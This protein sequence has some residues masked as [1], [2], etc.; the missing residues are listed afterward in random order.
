VLPPETG[1]DDKSVKII[2]PEP[3]FKD[4]GGEVN[5]FTVTK[6]PEI[7][8]GSVDDGYMIVFELSKNS[9]SNVKS[10]E[11]QITIPV[12]LTARHPTNGKTSK[13]DDLI[14]VDISFTPGAS[15]GT[16]APTGRSPNTK[17]PATPPKP[18]AKK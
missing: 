7:V 11:G 18:P 9:G 12:L 17:T 16:K 2:M 14:S 6:Q 4:A 13:F 8:G 10:V 15:S 1:L 3:Q 5:G